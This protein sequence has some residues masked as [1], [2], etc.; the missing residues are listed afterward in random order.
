M[1]LR[2]K[3]ARLEAKLEASKV[4]VV[5]RLGAKFR[6]TFSK[7]KQVC[8]Q[9]QELFFGNGTLTRD[10]T[11]QSHAQP[12]KEASVQEFQPAITTHPSLFTKEEGCSLNK[13]EAGITGGQTGVED[14]SPFPERSL[15][16]NGIGKNPTLRTR[17]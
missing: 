3:N 5:K 17:K 1:G 4:N 2:L 10:R 6:K 11:C 14:D 13:S 16:N 7:K 15:A 8:N 9:S 12:Q